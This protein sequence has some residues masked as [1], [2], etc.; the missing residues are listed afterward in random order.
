M[1]KIA[2]HSVF[3]KK[4]ARELIESISHF[5]CNS[6]I[7]LRIEDLAIS[8]ASNINQQDI[9]YQ[10]TFIDPK[11]INRA[12]QKNQALLRACNNKKKTI[13][14]ILDLTAGWGKDSFMLASQGHQVQMVEQNRL[15]AACLQYLITIAV[16]EDDYSACQRLQIIRDNSLS[17]LEHNDAPIADCIYLDPMFPAHKSSAKPSKDLQ[18]LQLLTENLSIEETFHLAQKLAGQRVVVKRPLHAPNLM[19]RKADI[20]YKEKTIRF[21]VYLT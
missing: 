16:K 4:Q 5:S 19:D 14:T 20:V 7:T 1:L 9:C 18:I 11:L 15:L 8:L 3:Y 21:D 17:F 2:N 13:H 10:H 6:S 12:K